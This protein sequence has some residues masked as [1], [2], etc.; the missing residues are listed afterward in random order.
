VSPIASKRP[1]SRTSPAPFV[2]RRSTLAFSVASLV[3]GVVFQA[4]LSADSSPSGTTG[5]L[6]ATALALWIV[7]GVVAWIAGV[8][9]ALRVNSLLW[10]VVA[11]MPFPPINSLLTAMFCPAS[12]ARRR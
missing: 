6:L 9:L 7:A 12:Q 11:V 10:L 8:V 1:A 5:M 2:T 4:V 3:A